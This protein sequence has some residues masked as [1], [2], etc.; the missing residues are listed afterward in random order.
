MDR[1]GHRIEYTIILRALF[2]LNIRRVHYIIHDDP[3]R[4][5]IVIY[6]AARVVVIKGCAGHEN[7]I[8]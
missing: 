8:V 7:L 4:F 2:I 6:F 1:I 5:R 3:A